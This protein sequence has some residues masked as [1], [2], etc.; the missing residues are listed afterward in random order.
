MG[1]AKRRKKFDPTWGKTQSIKIEVVP[2]VTDPNEASDIPAIRN[3]IKKCEFKVTIISYGLLTLKN[4]SIMCALIGNKTQSKLLFLGDESQEKLA[5]E[6]GKHYKK[7]AAEWGQILS[8]IK[9]IAPGKNGRYVLLARDHELT[10][11]IKI[12]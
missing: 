11:N 3:Y 1:E 8:K 7:I 6:M 2:F 9:D 5:K 12:N 10:R 4:R